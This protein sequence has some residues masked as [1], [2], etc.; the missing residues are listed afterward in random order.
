MKAGNASGD[1]SNRTCSIMMY[2]EAYTD[3]TNVAFALERRRFVSRK[4]W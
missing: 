3:D 2:Y 4:G 1:A